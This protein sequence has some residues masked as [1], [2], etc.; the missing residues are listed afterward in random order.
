MSCF[1]RALLLLLTHTS[2][3]HFLTA[4]GLFVKSLFVKSLFETKGKLLFK[5]Q[6]LLRFIKINE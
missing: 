2:I 5:I 6:I 3:Y 1:T 4:Q